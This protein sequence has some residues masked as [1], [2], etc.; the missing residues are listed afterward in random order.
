MTR[1]NCPCCGYPTLEERRGWEICCLCNW[2]DDGQDDPH[3]D[4][5][6]GGPN[7]DYS[8]TEARENFKKYYIMY[9]DRQIILKQTDKEI[10]TK[11]SLINAFEKLRTADNESVQ[12]IWQDIDSFEKVLD[13]IVHESTERYSNNIEK[14]QEI[15]NLINSD[16]PDTIVR[17]FLS[18]A[19]NADD[20]EFVQELMVRYTQHNNENIRGIAILCF[21]HIA[22]IHGAVNKELIIPLINDALNDESSFVRGHAN[23]DLDDIN[24]F[25]R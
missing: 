7:Q 13:D 22:R 10:Q 2:E 4:N 5:V 6:W 18:L 9:R 1:F 3:A 14:N 8:L 11:K 17:G 23:S 20:G 12:Q 19:L 24:M 21:G 25:C 16:N 15:I